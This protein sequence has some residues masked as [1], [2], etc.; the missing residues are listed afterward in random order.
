MIKKRRMLWIKISDLVKWGRRGNRRNKIFA[1]VNCEIFLC[2]VGRF[3]IVQKQ[4]KNEL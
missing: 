1:L 2:N 4:I 3:S